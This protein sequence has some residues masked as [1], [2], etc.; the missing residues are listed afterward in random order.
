MADTGHQ[1]EQEVKLVIQS[2]SFLQY[3]SNGGETIIAQQ[4]AW[5]LMQSMPPVQ[6]TASR[7]SSAVAMWPGLGQKSVT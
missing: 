5:E 6:S 7:S 1:K 4:N 3:E 2:K